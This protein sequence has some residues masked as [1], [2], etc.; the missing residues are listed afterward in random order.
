LTPTVATWGQH[1]VPDRIKPSF[2]I[3]DNGAL[4]LTTEYQSVRMSK[5]TNEGLTRSGTG[6]FIAVPMWQ[7]SASKG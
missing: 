2:V 3:L 5:I 7:Q 4:T 1:P 6:C